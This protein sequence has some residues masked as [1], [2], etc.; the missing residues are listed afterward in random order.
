MFLKGKQESSGY[1]EEVVSELDKLKYQ[2]DYYDNE[3]VLLDL[4]KIQKNPGKRF[5]YKL[6]LNSMWGRL[7]MNSDRNQYKIINNTNEWL[8]MVCDDQFLITS[9]DMHNPNCIQVY[10]K[11][12]YNEGSVETSVIHAAMVTCYARLQLYSVLKKLDRRVLYFDTDSIIYVAK[13]NEYRPDLGNYLGEL[14]NEIDPEDGDYIE[15]FVSAGPKNYAYRTNKGVTKCTV[16]GFALNNLTK[17]KLNFD[18]IK[19]L[20]TTDQSQKIELEQL[21]FRRDKLNWTVRS[22]IINQE[23][24]FVYDKRFLCTDFS[25]LPF[26]FK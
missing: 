15:E 16:K 26:A 8:E 2:F 17:L 3:G 18:S 7:G 20:V 14:T 12:L 24:G 23:Y 5:V 25:T 4:E 9:V 1:P 13:D 10:Y 6:A 11:N 19:T 21:K 22:D